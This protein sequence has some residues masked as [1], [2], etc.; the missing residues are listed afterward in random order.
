MFEI[1][2]SEAEDLHG[3]LL[4]CIQ[5]TL[6]SGALEA[7]AD[8]FKGGKGAAEVD[9]KLKQLVGKTIAGLLDNWKEG[10]ALSRVSLPKLVDFDWTLHMKKSSSEVAHLDTPSVM[11]S[12]SIEDQAQ[13]VANMPTCHDV[14]FELSREALET[15]IEGFSKIRDQLGKMG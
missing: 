7:L 13:N 8:L 12:L 14:Q 11:V 1:T 15:V 5:V 2:H 4:E 9:P 10:A 3:A 6:A